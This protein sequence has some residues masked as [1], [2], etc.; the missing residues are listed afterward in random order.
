[1]VPYFWYILCAENSTLALNN[2]ALIASIPSA[3]LFKVI[4]LESKI[5][6]V[7]V[8]YSVE[9][10]LFLVMAR[11]DTSGS[12]LVTGCYFPSVLAVC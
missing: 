8:A 12:V 4:L 9:L 2:V 5:V 11:E 10:S 7:F 3:L 6:N 1:M